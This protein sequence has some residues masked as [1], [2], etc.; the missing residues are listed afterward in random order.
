MSTVRRQYD[1][2][3]RGVGTRPFKQ[4]DESVALRGRER[5]RGIGPVQRDPELAAPPLEKDGVVA[6]RGLLAHA[7]ARL[8]SWP[9]S[10]PAW[11]CS[12]RPLSNARI[13]TS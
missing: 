3:G 5:V 1:D 11:V 7:V 2:T 9:M 6:R 4:F 13:E 8:A 10:M 12:N